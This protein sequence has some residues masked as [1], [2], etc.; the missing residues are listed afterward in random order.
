MRLFNWFKKKQ[1]P[2]YDLP[3]PNEY[4]WQ[5]VRNATSAKELYVVDKVAAE[6]Q[7][8]PNGALRQAIQQQLSRMQAP[9]KDA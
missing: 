4:L 5:R 9:T 8:H 3:D 1:Q 7:F 2:V 6:R